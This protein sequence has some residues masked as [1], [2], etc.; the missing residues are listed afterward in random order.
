MIDQEGALRKLRM[1]MAAFRLN[2]KE[3]A[4]QLGVSPAYLS[5]VMTSKKPPS[6]KMLDA[7]KLRRV[8]FYE[9]VS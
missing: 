1:H 3:F 6:K 8:V 4:Q 5:D 9:E 2:Q 7:V